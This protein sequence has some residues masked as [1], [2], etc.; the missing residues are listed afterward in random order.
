MLFAI[1]DLASASASGLDLAGANLKSI[2]AFKSHFGGRLTPNYG[3][4]TYSIRTAGR[5]VTDWRA[6]RRARDEP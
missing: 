2:A 1:D 5:F 4:R 6:A 3:V